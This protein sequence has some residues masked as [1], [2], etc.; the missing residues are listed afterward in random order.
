MLV[1]RK[2]GEELEIIEE[3]LDEVECAEQIIEVGAE[4]GA[5]ENLNIELSINSVVGLTNPRTMK[6]KGRMKEEEVMV[7]VDCGAT[8][9]FISEK[10]VSKLN[11]PMKAT[12]NY[13]F[14]KSN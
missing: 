8:H 2:N 13:G 5:V 10:L 3:G 7:L 14:C 12:T 9:N 11:L 4:V 6:G 1:V